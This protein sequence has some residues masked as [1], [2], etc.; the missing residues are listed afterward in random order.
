MTPARRK[1]LGIALLVVGGVALT[2]L[3]ALRAFE[4]NLL[5]FYSPT[6]VVAG[7]APTDRRFRLGGLVADGSVRREPG[8]LEMSFVVTDNRERITIAYD[9]GQHG[10]LP[11][12]FREGQGIIAHGVLRDDGVFVADE[13]LA[14]HDEN[15]TAPEV[16]EALE[17][18]SQP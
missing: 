14:R 3:L 17:A 1:R 13:L 18:G 12:L 5:F 10:P 7:E 16:K 8:S 2:V 9:S 6:Q 15:Y 11:N 4:E